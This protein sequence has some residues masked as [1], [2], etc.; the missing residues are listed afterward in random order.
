MKVNGLLTHIEGKGTVKNDRINMAFENITNLLKYITGT[1]ALTF[2]PGTRLERQKKRTM[3]WVVISICVTTAI[4]LYLY[5]TW[6][7]YYLAVLQGSIS[8]ENW[9]GFIASFWGAIEGA[10]ISGIATIITTWLIIR[11]SYKIDYHRERIESLPILQLTVREDIKKEIRHSKNFQKVI[12]NYKI[13]NRAW[14]ELSEDFMVFEVKN[15]G[16]GLAIQPKVSNEGEEAV[17]GAPSFSSISSQESVYF[18]EEWYFIF[19]HEFVFSFFDIFENYY[20]QKFSLD[21][22]DD[23]QVTDIKMSIPELVMKT[24]RIRYEQ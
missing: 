9:L 7:K 15:I 24:Q 17:Y 14:E 23:E 22:D 6:N 4:V 21:I 3:F 11:R 13:W 5:I 12:K 18:I 2:R 20:D 10:L 8:Q 1:G 19:N 16:K